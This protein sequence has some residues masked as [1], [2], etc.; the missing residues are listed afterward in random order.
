MDF[1]ASFSSEIAC[2]LGRYRNMAKKP[3]EKW[4]PYILRCADDS[5]YTGIT[6]DVSRRCKQ[7]NAGTG[8]RYTR[9]RRPVEVAY[10]EPQSSHSAA[11]KREF[12]VKALSRKEKKSLIRQGR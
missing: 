1:G 9:G 11:L 7:H 10:Q 2:L 6:K 5:L 3:Q 4:F 8:S 12:A